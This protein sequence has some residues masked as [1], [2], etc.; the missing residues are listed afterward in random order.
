MRYPSGSDYIIQ[1]LGFVGMLYNT[2]PVNRT[3]VCARICLALEARNVPYSIAH[4]IEYYPN[5]LGRDIDV[6]VPRESIPAALVV[7]AG[8]AEEV[9]WHIVGLQ[10]RAFGHYRVFCEACLGMSS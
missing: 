10:K 8:A 6:A 4:G 1:A 7:L 3:E 2:T 9:L 5:N